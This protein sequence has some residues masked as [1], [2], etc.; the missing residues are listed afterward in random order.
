[1]LLSSV[2]LLLRETLEVVLLV[3]VL[4]AIGYLLR[5]TRH[6]LAFG[7][8]AGLV[9]ALVYASNLDAISMWFEYVGQEITNATMQIGI[10]LVL[11]ILGWMT[12][13]RD[14]SRQQAFQVLAAIALAI[15][16][17]REGSEIFIYLSGFF[18]QEDKLQAVLLGGGI[19]FC[20]G[21]SVGVL[22]FYG[23]VALPRKWGVATSMALMALIAGN[24]LSQAVLQLTQADWI[25]AG[26]ALWDSA[27]VVAENSL[28]GQLLYALVGYEATPSPVQVVAYLVGVVMV[29]AAIFV[30]RKSR[31]AVNER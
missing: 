10:A 24:M 19:G 15:A 16:I 13:R 27:G 2:V 22:L 17:A 3:G 11:V 28:S 9:L 14:D 25:S 23:L 7:L 5:F 1:M 18:R 30:G 26:Q 8:L 4:M 6:W 12:G 20:I 29:S 31:E 21:I